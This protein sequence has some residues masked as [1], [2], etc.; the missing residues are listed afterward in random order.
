VFAAALAAGFLARLALL[1]TSIGTNDARFFD[2]WSALVAQYGI[3][4]A[5]AHH[6]LLNHPPLSLLIVRW[7]SAAAVSLRVEMTDLLR[8]VQTFADVGSAGCLVYLGRQAGFG[9][10]RAVALVYFLSPA[11]IFVSGFHCNTDPTMVFLILLAITLRIQ[12]WDVA[13]GVALALATGIKILPILILPLF[14]VGSGRWRFLAAF[15][16]VFALVFVPAI[17]TGGAP[18]ARN[19]FGYAGLPEWWGI[20]AMLAH[21]GVVKAA[22]AYVAIARYVTLLAV[23]LVWWRFASADK[24]A[25]RFLGAAGMTYLAVLV[26]APALGVQYLIWPLPF[27]PFAAGWRIAVSVHAAASLFIF[28]MY[29]SWSRGWPWWYADSMLHPWPFE[30]WLRLGSYVVWAVLLYALIR[31]NKPPP[32]PVS[33]DARLDGGQSL[34]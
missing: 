30:G 6:P 3:A 31:A 8:L 21:L 9:S 1:L 11:A 33:A 28:G 14:L 29:T 34:W 12:R 4:G 2:A 5:Y 10:G 23:G 27:L 19:I 15:T 22:V 18:V 16:T 20:A 7:L 13:A 24:T 17:A 26:V 32:A 25:V